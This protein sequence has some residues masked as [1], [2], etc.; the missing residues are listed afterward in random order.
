MS[1]AL[2]TPMP[3]ASAAMTV[4]RVTAP[5]RM[6]PVAIFV[7]LLLAAAGAGAVVYFGLPYVR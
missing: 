2:T 4:A 1:A 3:E 7:L 6:G 5:K